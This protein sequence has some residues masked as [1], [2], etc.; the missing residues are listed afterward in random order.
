M[1][2][3][4]VSLRSYIVI[5]ERVKEAV[6]IQELLLQDPE[7]ILNGNAEG[8]IVAQIFYDVFKVGAVMLCPAEV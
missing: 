5:R 2:D 3:R 1:K 6:Q 7:N 4:C 8:Y